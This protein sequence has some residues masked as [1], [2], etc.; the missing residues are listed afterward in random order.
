MGN[1]TEEM[2][3]ESPRLFVGIE[4]DKATQKYLDAIAVHCRQLPLPRKVRWLSHSNRHLTLAFLGETPAAQVQAIEERL[5]SIAAAFP[6]IHASA[7]GTLPF[8]KPRSRLLATELLPNP[9]LDALH[10]ACRQLMIDFG[11]RPESATYRPHFTIARARNGF[12]RF[13]PQPSA[14][15]CRLDNLVLYQSLMAPGGSQYAQLLKLRFTG[16]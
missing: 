8:P 4:P 5:T 15:V 14:H 10:Q 2:E 7:V 6:V 1:E 16:D 9:E 13:P 11:M 12:A 3:A